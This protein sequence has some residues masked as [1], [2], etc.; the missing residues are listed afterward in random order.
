MAE[1]ASDDRTPAGLRRYLLTAVLGVVALALLGGGA[2]LLL[3]GGS[4]YY[5]AAGALVAVSAYFAFYNDDRAI[6]AYVAL[7]VLT[8]FWGAWETGLDPWGM[9]ARLFAPA[10]ARQRLG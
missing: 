9:Q 1:A 10:V 7:L 5:V 8:L 3:L 6:W 2:Q 4:A